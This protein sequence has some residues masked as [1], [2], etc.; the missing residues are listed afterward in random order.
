MSIAMATIAASDVATHGSNFDTFS[1]SSQ[2]DLIDHHPITST[3]TP[4]I[5]RNQW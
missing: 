3:S 2:P 4:S 5:D 1:A